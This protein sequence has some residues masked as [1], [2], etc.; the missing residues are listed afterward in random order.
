[1]LH[2]SP[3]KNL[4]VITLKKDIQITHVWSNIAARKN[5]GTQ[6]DTLQNPIQKLSKKPWNNKKNWKPFKKKLKNKKNLKG[7]AKLKELSQ[8]KMLWYE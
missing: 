7:Q 2:K 6:E 1:M 4:F 3:L 5:H 8:V